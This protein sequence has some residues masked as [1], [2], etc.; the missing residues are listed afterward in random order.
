MAILC[1]N[2]QLPVGQQCKSGQCKVVH[3]RASTQ[4]EL[5]HN[6]HGIADSPASLHTGKAV[7][8]CYMLKLL[9]GASFEIAHDLCALL[10]GPH[11][12]DGLP[13]KLTAEVLKGTGL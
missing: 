10:I 13:I 9:L 5:C 7:L 8:L 4:S 3:T 12:A 1:C 2:S 6:R 11:K